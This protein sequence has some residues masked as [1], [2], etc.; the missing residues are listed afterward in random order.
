MSRWTPEEVIAIRA[1]CARGCISCGAIIPEGVGA[2][3][4]RDQ[5]APGGINVRCDGCVDKARALAWEE[6]R[7]QAEKKRRIREFEYSFAES[8]VGSQISGNPSGVERALLIE[9]LQDDGE[10]RAGSF[11]VPHANGPLQFPRWKWSRLDNPEFRRRVSPLILREVESY[12][13]DVDGSMVIVGKSGAGK[14]SVTAAWVWRRHDEMRARVEAGENLRMSFAWVSGYELAGARKRSQLG[15]ESPLVRHASQ[16]ALLIL[17]EVGHE[18]VSEEIMTVID[19]RYRAE[20]PTILTSPLEWKVLAKHIGGG[21]Y[22]RLLEHGKLVDTFDEAPANPGKAPL[23][24][25]R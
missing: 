8:C 25:V 23:R 9:W 11:A 22:R 4:V 15:E 21:A 2:A 20:L 16:V 6:R 24:A 18:S 7:A 12:D 5:S 3:V 19:A 14:S 13:P 1:A 10:E 17:D